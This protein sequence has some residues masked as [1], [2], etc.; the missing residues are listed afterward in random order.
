MLV[1]LSVIAHS[2]DAC[3]SLKCLSPTV[4][5]MFQFPVARYVL[6]PTM[7]AVVDL[8]IRSFRNWLYSW[9]TDSLF[10]IA[11]FFFSFFFFVMLRQCHVSVLVFVFQRFAAVVLVRII[12]TAG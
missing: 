9:R 7:L 8:L 4:L 5:E 1:Q 12:H 6:T 10:P 2:P 11:A 3:A